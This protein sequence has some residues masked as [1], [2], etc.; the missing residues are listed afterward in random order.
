MIDDVR[1]PELGYSSNFE[2]DDGGWVSDGWVRMDN[3]VPQTWAV[4][5]IEY[6]PELKVTRLPLDAANAG[7]VT[8]TL[9]EN[10]RA[11]IIIGAMAPLTQ[12]NA[13]Y[14]LQI[15][16]PGLMT[17]INAPP[18]VLFQDDF[19]NPCGDFR[20]L[21]LPDYE[22]GYLDGVFKMQI[23]I[24]QTEVQSHAGKEFSNLAM[25]VDSTFVSLADG[26]L[27]GVM[28]RRVDDHNYYLFAITPDG[29]FQ[30]GAV[31]EGSYRDLVPPTKASAIKT[32]AGA[33]N[34][35]RVS[36]N[37]DTLTLTVN[38]TILGTIDD[39]AFTKGDIG[40]VALTGEFKGT[41]E[42]LRDL[43]MVITFDNLVVSRPE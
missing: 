2:D 16:G 12:V 24:E 28:C 29:M 3:K 27:L 5:L 31:E 43:N 36:C 14:S 21:I 17:S 20:S 11:T 23:G 33:Q 13:Q 9:P 6:E 42:Q 18:G 8:V 10:G 41:R 15:G 1:V 34:H 39:K 25:E 37:N 32:G 40:F 22:Y 26:E 30:I 7:Q 4:W 35:L 19:E 38:G